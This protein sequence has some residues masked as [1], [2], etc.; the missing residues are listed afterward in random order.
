MYMFGGYNDLTKTH[1][2]DLYKLDLVNYEWSKVK[3]YGQTPRKRRRQCC[4]V[5][6]DQVIMFGGTR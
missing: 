4:I 1:F 5:V 2:N 6:G 3:T